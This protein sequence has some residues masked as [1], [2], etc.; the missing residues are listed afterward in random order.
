MGQIFSQSTGRVLRISVVTITACVI[1][2]VSLLAYL[3]QPEITDA[4]YQ[5]KQPVPFRHK[6][7][8]GNLGMDCRCCHSAVEFGAHAAIPATDTCMNCHKRV[9]AESPLLAAVLA[10]A[11][12]DTPVPWVQ[13]HKLPEYA[14]FNHQAHLSAGVSCLSCHGRVDQMAERGG[15]WPR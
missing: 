11:A 5:P 12:N 4:G 6:L 13:V 15:R 14:Y 9:R 1:G 7:H 3:G 10:S 2:T 8:A